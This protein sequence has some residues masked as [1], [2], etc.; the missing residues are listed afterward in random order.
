MKKILMPVVVFFGIFS[1]S[2]QA[3]TVYV[4]NGTGGMLTAVV[5]PCYGI[6]NTNGLPAGWVCGYSN[7]NVLPYI[8]RTTNQSIA[9]TL[10]NQPSSNPPTG[11]TWSTTQ[12]PYAYVPYQYVS[13]VVNGTSVKPMQPWASGGDGDCGATFNTGTVIQLSAYDSMLVC[14][15]VT[16]TQN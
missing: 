4:A 8:I 15:G 11:Y 9:V 1:A 6:V 5:Q 3:G 14:N 16:A 2:T 12:T 7:T 10:P 13:A